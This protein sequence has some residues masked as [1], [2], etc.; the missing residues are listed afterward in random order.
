MSFDLVHRR[1]NF[2]RKRRSERINKRRESIYIFDHVSQSFTMIQKRLFLLLVILIAISYSYGA[3]RLFKNKA[4]KEEKLC[5]YFGFR[6]PRRSLE[7]IN[8]PSVNAFLKLFRTNADKTDSRSKRTDSFDNLRPLEGPISI[9]QLPAMLAAR[10]VKQ[11]P[12]SREDDP[13]VM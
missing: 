7:I 10:N 1:R 13:A 3:P 6:R 9:E 5:F 12:Y 2:P 11:Y 8:W 4:F